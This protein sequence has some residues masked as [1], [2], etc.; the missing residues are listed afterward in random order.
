MHIFGS[1]PRPA[2]AELWGRAQQSVYNPLCVLRFEKHCVR[3]L[4]G[5]AP[6]VRN[7]D[8]LVFLYPA[9]PVASMGAVGD[10]R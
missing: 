5:I 10:G 9:R 8:K 4:L 7:G 6:L 3:V 2:Q 1:Y